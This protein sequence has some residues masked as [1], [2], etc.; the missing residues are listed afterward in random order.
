M[1]PRQVAWFEVNIEGLDPIH[2]LVSEED[3]LS[4]EDLMLRRED[5]NLGLVGIA[6]EAQNNGANDADQVID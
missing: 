1:Q 3:D 5:D 6:V 4:K 2:E